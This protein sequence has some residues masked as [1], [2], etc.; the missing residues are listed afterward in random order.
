VD[1]ERTIGLSGILYDRF[2]GG[3]LDVIFAERRQGDTRGTVA[4]KE[5]LVWIGREGFQPDPQMPLP[6]LLYPPPSITRALALEALEAVGRPWRVACTSGSLS[7]IYAVAQAGPGLAPHSER[8]VPPGLA[9]L[10]PMPDLPHLGTVDF[11]LIGPGRHH[12]V[13]TALIHVVLEVAGRLS[14][15]LT[16]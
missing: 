2:D 3:H 14:Q 7:G 16:G 1:L 12:A 5:R 10:P 8:L 11:V 15:Q 13:A 6:W 4:W 9:A